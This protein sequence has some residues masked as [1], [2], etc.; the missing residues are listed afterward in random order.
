MWGVRQVETTPPRPW[1]KIV[2]QLFAR[3]GH[4][5]A[6]VRQHVRTLITHIGSDLPDA[7]IYPTV[8]LPPVMLRSVAIRND[9]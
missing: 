3:L 8:S 6:G 7:I 5:E 1:R 4:A 9:M 2:P